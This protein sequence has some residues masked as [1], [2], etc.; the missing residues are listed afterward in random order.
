MITIE[1]LY[2]NVC[3]QGAIHIQ[4]FDYKEGCLHTHYI[5]D[6]E[7][8]NDE[9]NETTYET[10]KDYEIKYLFAEDNFTVIE[11]QPME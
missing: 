10:I 8:L 11:V 6:A 7:E 1:D 2:D 3:V 4:E 5:G 9:N